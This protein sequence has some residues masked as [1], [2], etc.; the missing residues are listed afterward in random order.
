M[1][2]SSSVHLR[3]FAIDQSS[4]RSF[5]IDFALCSICIW[6]L[7]VAFAI[8]SPCFHGNL[9]IY[10]TAYHNLQRKKLNGITLDVRVRISVRQRNAVKIEVFIAFKTFDSK[11]ALMENGTACESLSSM[12]CMH[13][14]CVHAALFNCLLVCVFVFTFF[15]FSSSFSL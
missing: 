9:E 4:M 3:K 13:Y 14:V 6:I 8:N 7:V 10:F 15:A 1:Q 5:P 11:R 12:C 2:V